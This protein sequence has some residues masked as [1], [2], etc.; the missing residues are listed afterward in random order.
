MELVEGATL[1]DRIA[2]G[3]IPLDE[4]LPIACQIAE[5]LEYAH[6]HGIIHRDLKPANIELTGDDQVKVLDFGLAKAMDP[7]EI[8]GESSDLSHSPTMV[9]RSTMQ[10]V[11]LGTAGYMAPEQ[12]AGKSVDKRADIWAFGVV[13]YEMLAGMTLFAG[14]SV[15]KRLAG[16]M[17]GEIDL[18][19]LPDDVPGVIRRLLGRCLERNPQD[20]LRDIGDARL[21]LRDAQAGE[22]GVDD[23]GGVGRGLGRRWLVPAMLVVGLL[24]GFLLAPIFLP[25]TLQGAHRSARGLRSRFR[26]ACRS[27]PATSCRS[28]CFRPTGSRSPMVRSDPM[29]CA[30]WPCGGSTRPRRG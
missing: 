9:V 24:A 19:N 27:P 2:R 4:A 21:D 5:A 22:T 25:S 17:K 1:A 26:P 14:D 18:D 6:E 16:V 8:A 13:L 15:Q 23:R 7:T 11:I 12:A 30:G 20:R 3:P 10:G 28:L 29:A